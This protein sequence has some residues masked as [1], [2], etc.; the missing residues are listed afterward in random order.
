MGIFWHALKHD[1]TKYGY[2]EFH[3]SKKHY[4]GTSS[5]VFEERKEN[6]NF[7]FICQHHTKRNPHH[8]E[9]WTDWFRGDIIVCT[10]PYKYA[11]EYVCDML[12]ASKVYSGKKNFDPHNAVKYF[13]ERYP[14]FYMTQATIEFIHWALIE[15]AQNG[16]KNLKKKNTK[17][18]YLEITSK[19]PKFETIPGPRSG[20]RLLNM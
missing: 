17:A 16:W 13:E 5:P 1:L 12:A 15:Y 11:V 10:M 2:T 6:E 19:Y 18:K 14:Y 7:S 9:Y 3:N 4:V 20:G 8:W